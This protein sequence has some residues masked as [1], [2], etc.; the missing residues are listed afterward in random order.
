MGTFLAHLPAT[1]HEVTVSWLNSVLSD[2]PRW[3]HGSLVSLDLE[4]VGGSDSLA[5]LVFKAEIG[6]ESGKTT[7]LIVKMQ[8]EKTSLASVG[9]EAEAYFYNHYAVD[10]GVHVPQTYWSAFD[11]ETGRLMILQDFLSNGEVGTMSTPLDRDTAML[12]IQSLVNMHAKWWESDVLRH[13]GGMRKFD[14]TTKRVADLL[15]DPQKGLVSGFLEKLGDQLSTDMRRFFETMPVWMNSL[16]AMPSEQSTMIHYDCSAKNIFF[17]SDIEQPP[18]FFDW[19]F[20]HFGPAAA[21]LA[22]L[23]GTSL[24]VEDQPLVPDMLDA[25]LELLKAR[26][27]SSLSR[28][29]LQQDFVHSTMRRCMGPVFHANTGNPDGLEQA[30]KI[31]PIRCAAVE[32]SGA[33]EAAIALS[34]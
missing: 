19:A 9:F 7:S 15:S 33:L 24:S 31:L 10:A 6:L 27:L 30:A 21:D 5:S 32:S 25:Y 16:A 20:V 1:Q 29:E 13:D 26:G 34:S 11:K 2:S 8:P 12:C 18:V 28:D 3:D 4:P 17:P 22:V 14:S 23:T